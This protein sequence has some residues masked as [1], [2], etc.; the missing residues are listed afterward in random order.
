MDHNGR[1][2]G[3]WVAVHPTMGTEVP[4]WL[5]SFDSMSTNTT[6]FASYSSFYGAHTTPR[7]LGLAK[8]TFMFANDMNVRP[9]TL[10]GIARRVRVGMVWQPVGGAKDLVLKVYTAQSCD[11]DAAAEGPAIKTKYSGVLIKK[12]AQAPSSSLV[13]DADLSALAGGVPIPRAQG[14]A[15]VA[16]FGTTDA[17]GNFAE[18]PLGDWAAQPLLSNMNSPSEP[19]FPG[20]NPSSSTEYDWEDDTQN[21]PSIP[22]PNYYFEDYTNTTENGFTPY[23]EQYSNNTGS[24][25]AGGILQPSSALFV[26]SNMR[27]ISGTII[28]NNYSVTGPAPVTALITIAEQSNG[29][30]LQTM[31]VP[32][33]SSRTYLVPDPKQT[34]G[35]TYRITVK[36]TH[37]LAKATSNVV[38]TA[39]NTTFN[40]T[41]PVNGDIVGDNIIDIADYTELAA[42]FSKTSADPDWL[43]ERDSG[44][45][46]FDAD[47]N[48]DAIIDIADYTILASN[49]SAVGD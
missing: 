39:G 9:T 6:S 33:S 16:E 28:L 2:V 27:T 46:P 3:P 12:L 11:V 29:T 1:Q 44:Y 23:A 24:I 41:L 14:G 45:R 21:S 19:Y 15:F 18:I 30:I 20:T 26:D 35:G 49:F 43:V 31:E 8:K 34:T 37:W 47:L 13:V 7:H 32:L 17:G 36:A 38:T 5:M 10:G 22:Q 40:V 42:S 48:G 25:A 4:S